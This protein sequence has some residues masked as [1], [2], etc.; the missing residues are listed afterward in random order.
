MDILFIILIVVLIL[1]L[2]GGLFPVAGRWAPGYG[3]G[4][5]LNAGLMVVIIIIIVLIVVR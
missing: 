4:M 1:A 5:P 3:L 2:M